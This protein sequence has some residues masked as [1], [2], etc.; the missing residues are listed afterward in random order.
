MIVVEW[1]DIVTKRFWA[2]RVNYNHCRY[3]TAGWEIRGKQG[4]LH[5]ASS[6]CYDGDYGDVTIIPKHNVKGIKHYPDKTWELKEN[7]IDI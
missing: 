7:S 3:K 4:Y 6:Q 5:V 1:E 2:G